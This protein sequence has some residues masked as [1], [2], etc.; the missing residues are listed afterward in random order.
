M[1]K[2]THPDIYDSLPDE[3]RQYLKE[4][5]AYIN[6]RR[7][8]V[9]DLIVQIG[10]K[11]IEVREQHFAYYR[12]PSF[13]QW[14][15]AEF[16]ESYA[17]IVNYMNVAKRMANVDPDRH[18]FTYRGLYT[19]SRSTTSDAVREEALH[20]L[21]NGYK[22]DHD[23]AWVLANAPEYLRQRFLERTVT[24]EDALL[25][26]RA[27][28][29]ASAEKRQ[30][31]EE[32]SVISAEIVESIDERHQM[33]IDEDEGQLNGIGWNKAI[34]QATGSDYERWL[35]DRHQMHIENAIAETVQ[36]KFQARVG[37]TYQGM[38]VL[39]ILDPSALET[40]MG[41]DV[42]VTVKCKT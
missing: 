36:L 16:E 13:E 8:L 30:W 6:A 18:M 10:A 38:P 32:R 22:V 3:Q 25:T 28:K 2:N 9:Y 1:Q 12:R 26:T 5:A 17:T 23:T 24:K 31:C 29:A 15:E 34:A 19:L 35:A 27:L 41:K 14:C 37:K 7:A 11:L 42:E 4:S 21:E 39:L 20:L 33:L 40:I